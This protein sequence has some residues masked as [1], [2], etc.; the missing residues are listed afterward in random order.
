[1]GEARGVAGGLWVGAQVDHVDEYLRVALRL[2]A[3]AHESEGHDGLTV[4][5]E[6]SR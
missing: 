5:H 6:K 3:A 1:M 2:L 4:L